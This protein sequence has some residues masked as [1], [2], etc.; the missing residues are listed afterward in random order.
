MSLIS[1][2]GSTFEPWAEGTLTVAL[3]II[4]V[5]V[6]VIG[7]CL[8]VVTFVREIAAQLNEVALKIA[9]LEERVDDL[10]EAA[11]PAFTT[12]LGT[13]GVTIFGLVSPLVGACASVVFA[14]VTFAFASLAKNPKVGPIR[15][16]LAAAAAMSPLAGLVAAAF[17]SGRLG[18]LS[19]AAAIALVVL[20]IVGAVGL[21]GV[22][23]GALRKRIPDRD[24]AAA[25]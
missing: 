15:R 23:H 18:G 3:S 9:K 19:P 12:C 17:V 5:L 21:L 1:L 14:L 4:A 8:L 25:A 16:W 7:G 20:F 24:P 6:T 11:L 13:V 2:F 10:S 22:I